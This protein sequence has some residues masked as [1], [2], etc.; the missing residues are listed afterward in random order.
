MRKPPSHLAVPKLVPR[1]RVSYWHTFSR[2]LWSYSCSKA[3]VYCVWANTNTGGCRWLA[4]WPTQ[5]RQV[6]RI[7]SLLAYLP[8]CPSHSCIQGSPRAF[9]IPPR[10]EALLDT[11]IA[12][13]RKW[14]PPC[15][16]TT[17][18]TTTH[19]ALSVFSNYNNNNN[20]KDESVSS[21]HFTPAS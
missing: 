8:T 9:A 18:T 19:P 20:N 3:R 2:P 16:W 4:S 1:G 10:R 11:A 7:F 17:T 21:S 12:R 14:Y 15:C 13:G 6:R 5:Q